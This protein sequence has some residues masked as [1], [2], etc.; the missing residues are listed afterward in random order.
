MT[1][2]RLDFVVAGV[3]KAGT[4]S[5]DSLLRR[6]SGIAMAA[7]KETHFFDDE[8]RDWIRPDYG[9]LHAALPPGP[10]LRGEATPITFYWVPALY[11]LREYRR[12][13]LLVVIF[14]DPIDRALSHWKMRRAAARLGLGGPPEQLSF[15][16]AIDAPARLRALKSAEV[17]GQAR[18]STYVDRGRYGVQLRHA[19]TVFPREQMLLLDFE[20]LV[21]R[22]TSLLDSVAGFLGVAP[23]PFAGQPLHLHPG[24]ASAGEELTAE[25]ERQLASEYADDLKVFEDLSGLDVS[26]WRTRR[27][28]T[29]A[30]PLDR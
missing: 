9:P 16:D 26:R 28:I 22:Q 8:R 11:R 4:T 24:P 27:L 21:E 23:E 15:M 14:R 1:A 19:L 10:V 12:D 6:H 7:V 17:P 20:D 3:Q 29:A 18:T 5:L 30:S 2:A 13:M 25:A